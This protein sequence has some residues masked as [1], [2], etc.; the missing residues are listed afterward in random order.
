[1]YILRV[2]KASDLVFDQERCD[3]GEFS[4]TENPIDCTNTDIDAATTI[5]SED[6]ESFDSSSELTEAGWTL[7]NLEDGDY[8]WGLDEFS[9]N[10]YALANAFNTD[11]PVIDAWLITPPINLNGTTE[12]EL[13]FQVQT[14][15][16]GGEVL[17]VWVS[18]DFQSVEDDSNWSL[19]SDVEIPEGP[20]NGFGSFEDVGPVNLSCIEEDTVRIGFRYQGSDPG[21]T[22]RYHI[23]NITIEGQN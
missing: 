12:E 6:F 7:I 22:T 19:L 9:D 5:F 21:I 16:D 8:N 11:Q 18:T 10:N 1:M 17:S 2:N 3:P 4:F 15:F 20:P 13:N 23:D 14:N